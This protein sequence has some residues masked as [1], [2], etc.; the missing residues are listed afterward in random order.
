MVKVHFFFLYKEHVTL[1]LASVKNAFCKV[2]FQTFESI[3]NY[4]TWNLTV[5]EF[6]Q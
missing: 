6:F 1:F 3:K 4:D 2:A 5:K